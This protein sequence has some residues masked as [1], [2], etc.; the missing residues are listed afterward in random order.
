MRFTKVHGL[1]N[2]FVLVEALSGAPVADLAQLAREV[3]DR[4]FGVGA[5]GLV[6]LSTSAVADLRMRIFN[7]DGSEAEMCGNAIRCIGKYA[8]ERG[9]CRRDE[10]SVETLAGIRQIGLHL[11]GHQVEA[12]TVDMGRPI[13][14]PARIPVQ[15]DRM[16]PIL[17]PVTGQDQVYRLTAVSMGN[18]HGVVFVPDL[19]AIDLGRQGARLAQHSIF[20]KGANIE[21][22]Q[23]I[24]SG[25]VK[26]KVYER[27][28]GPTLA[29]GTG[30]CAVG[31]ASV[32]NG[33]TD[34]KLWVE[35]PGGR[36][37]IHWR[38][39]QHVWMTG[40]AVLAYQGDWPI[41]AADAPQ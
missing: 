15:T 4:H 19:Q 22:V 10:M 38:N 40:P 17:L 2:D 23:V 31:V 21:F 20:P 3:C 41:R 28:V 5:D 26:A 24:D 6:L 36:L 30:A 34:D 14:Q 33:L 35:L 11:A 1:G 27:G 8:Y 25:Y 32:L 13:L 9:L 39:Q 12:V 16:P 18:P 29:C 37:H 7:A